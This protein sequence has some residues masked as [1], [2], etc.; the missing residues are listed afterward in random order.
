[1]ENEIITPIDNEKLI[2]E[3]TCPICLSIL[4]DPILTLPN[5][6][7]FCSKC[8][9]SYLIKKNLEKNPICPICKT[10][11]ES[12]MKPKFLNNILATIKMKC[13]AQIPDKECNFIGNSLEYYSHIKNCEIFKESIKIK[14]ENIVKKM[15]EILDKE[16]NPHLKT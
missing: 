15:K 3:L 4:N 10:S 1:M 6:H 2:Q 12:T 16:I 14:L 13:M 7:L 9:Y 8:F 11:I 5:Q